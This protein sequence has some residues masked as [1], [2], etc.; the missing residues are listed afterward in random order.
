[1]KKTYKL[2]FILVVF[3]LVF[4]LSACGF[5]SGQPT[6]SAPQSQVPSLEE[7]QTGLQTGFTVVDSRGIEV[8]FEKV[9]EKIVS[10][11]PSNTEILYSLNCGESIVAVSEYCNYPEETENKPKLPTGEMLNVEAILALEA[12]VVILGNM[13]AMEDQIYQLEESGVNV[14]V[15][16]ANNLSETFDV[17]GIIGKTVGKEEEAQALVNAMKEGFDDIRAAVER[18]KA[19]SIFVEVSPLEYGLWSCGRNTFIHELIEIVGANNIFEDIEGWSAVSEE[20]VLTRNPDVII[21]TASPLT[22]IDD[23]VGDIKSRANWNQTGAV[24]NDKVFMID[25]DMVTRPGPRLLDGAKELVK[26][27]Y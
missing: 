27:I 6:E 9:P 26:L 14:I 5:Q 16:E 24:K 10:L 15:T 3:S 7:N 2:L 22:G 1:M 8:P 4:L 19:V 12:D 21:T 11:M 18:N 17:I 13:S 23:P 20:Q 25:G